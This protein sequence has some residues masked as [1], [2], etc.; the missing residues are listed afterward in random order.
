MSASSPG[1]GQNLV[2]GKWVGAAKVKEIPDPLNGGTMMKVPDTAVSEVG[3][4]IERMK[5]CPRSG[6]HNPIKKP[7]RYSMLGA[8]MAD[9]AREMKKPEVAEFFARLIQRV[10]PKS[11]PQCTGEPTVARKFMENYSC[12][13][14][15]FLAQS[16]GVPGDH[17]G[18]VS[19]G[20]RFP[21]GG[22]SIITPFNFPL[23]IPALQTLSAL[24]MGNQP[25]TKVGA[26]ASALEP[27]AWTISAPP[28][29]LPLKCPSSACRPS[30]ALYTSRPFSQHTGWSH[31]LPYPHFTLRSC[32]PHPRSTNNTH[33]HT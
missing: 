29:S 21:Y 32:Q 28:C 24:F 10:V 14:V 27:L 20:L 26:S 9:T 25:L 15:R 17:A 4:Y 2:G 11:M 18:Q 13:Q 19:T 3:E 33:T 22:V 8:V 30:R 1:I 12:D 5:H 7:E 6:L 23:E 16:F 31:T